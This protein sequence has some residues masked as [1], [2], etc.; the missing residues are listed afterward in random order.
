[1]WGKEGTWPVQGL[2]AGHWTGQRVGSVSLSTDQ[3]ALRSSATGTT[4]PSWWLSLGQC[5]ES[6]P[7]SAP[8]IHSFIH[9][10][11]KYQ[12]KTGAVS[13]VI[14]CLLCKHKALSSNPSLTCPPPKFSH[15][16][17]AHPCN[18]SYSG[19]RDQEDYSSRNGKYPIDKRAGGVAQLVGTCLTSV[20]PWVQTL[21]PLKQANK[22]TKQLKCI[23]QSSRKQQIKKRFCPYETYSLAYED[24]KKQANRTGSVVQVAQVLSSNPSTA[25]TKTK[26]KIYHKKG[27]EVW[28]KW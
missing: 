7:V 23:R 15:V 20:R 14:E 16:L 21:V 1:M 11:I 26:P 27:L 25:K 2:F 9:S 19:D 6:I 13:Q 28:L 4:A 3:E 24:M 10:S 12:L 5:L 8:G 18:P 22:L 17:V